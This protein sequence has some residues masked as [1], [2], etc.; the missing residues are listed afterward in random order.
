MAET[1]LCLLFLF[2]T[3]LHLPSA[4][5]NNFTAH[6]SPAPG[7]KFIFS[8][9]VLDL[10]A[11]IA[12]DVLGQKI[13]GITIPG[14]HG[15][16]NVALLGIVNV[17][18]VDWEAKSIIF[19]EFTQPPTSVIINPNFFTWSVTNAGLK[20]KGSLEYD[21]T[22]LFLHFNRKIEFEL[23]VSEASAAVNVAL[24]TTQNGRPKVEVLD[25]A[26]SIGELEVKINGGESWVMNLF[27]AVI[28]GSLKTQIEGAVCI[29]ASEV[30][31][32]SGNEELA[33]LDVHVRLSDVYGLDCKLLDDPLLAKDYFLT[34]N[35][36]YCFKTGET[37]PISFTSPP[38]PS[39]L[40]PEKMVTLYMTPHLAETIGYVLQ[41]TG[42]FNARLSATNVAN[43]DSFFA[44][45][46]VG[47]VKCFGSLFPAA[48]TLYAGHRIEISA[49]ANRRPTVGANSSGF[50]VRIYWEADVIAVHPTSGAET[51]LFTLDISTYLSFTASVHGRT[52]IA[53]SAEFIP[54]TTARDSMI[55]TLPVDKL[56]DLVQF[57][58]DNYVLPK[59]K[60]VAEVGVTVPIVEGLELIDAE[61][62]FAEGVVAAEW[63]FK[64]HSP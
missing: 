32:T 33:T 53:H 16:T 25:C 39:L 2:V 57:C 13:H 19:T 29:A 22:V 34:S 42:A 41:T 28:K 62:R 38:F 15:R 10:A 27:A 54:T 21:Y 11:N 26:T 58:A 20:L 3:L 40:T 17:G 44:V 5:T 18:Y 48:L 14:L 37:T 7:A 35:L 23:T 55:G 60:E 61:I 46:C 36:C 56:N 49:V 50:N 4:F 1:K 8:H 43:G 12:V 31:H 59:I 63:N 52:M 51:T 47:R 45:T 30:V 64:Y 6:I 9:S 24:R